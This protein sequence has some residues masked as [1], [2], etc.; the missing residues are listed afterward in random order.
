MDVGFISTHLFDICSYLSAPL[1]LVIFDNRF[2]RKRVSCK[3]TGITFSTFSTYFVDFVSSSFF[4]GFCE[5]FEVIFGRVF[6]SK[7]VPNGAQNGFKK[8]TK[9]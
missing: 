1:I 2:I 7:M 9:I 8:V 3:S 6:F 4:I 5:F